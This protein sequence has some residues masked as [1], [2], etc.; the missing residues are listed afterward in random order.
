MR[1]PSRRR[2]AVSR[3]QT[4]DRAQE[5]HG[6][7]DSHRR[8]PF[9]PQPRGRVVVGHQVEEVLVVR[10]EEVGPDLQREVEVLRVLRVAVEG[11]SRGNLGQDAG[12]AAKAGQEQV[13][14]FVRDGGEFCPNAR[15]GQHGGQFG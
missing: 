11:V 3:G 2:A 1:V 8:Y 15:P 13:G 6:I 5:F 12:R 9:S 14:Q 4:F 7:D 10:D